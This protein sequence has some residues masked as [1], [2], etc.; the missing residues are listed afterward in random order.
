MSEEFK[1]GDKVRVREDSPNVLENF[2]EGTIVGKYE[3]KSHLGKLG[4]H[5]TVK[6]P[7]FVGHDGDIEDGTFD[8]WFF[9]GDELTK[10]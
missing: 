9:T 4:I 7:E 5:W 3:W 6:I 8:K 1:I 2:N 10:I